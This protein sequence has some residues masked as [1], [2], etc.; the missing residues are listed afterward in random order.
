MAQPFLN[1]SEAE[2]DTVNRVVARFVAEGNGDQFWDVYLY[3]IGRTDPIAHE[4]A[5]LDEGAPDELQ[6]YIDFYLGKLGLHRSEELTIAD[7]GEV[8]ARVERG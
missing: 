1:I 8:S 2:R 5:A 6:P 3:S 4:A 7:T